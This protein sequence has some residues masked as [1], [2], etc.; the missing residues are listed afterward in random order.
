MHNIADA[1][2]ALWLGPIIWN[3]GGSLG[4]LI[5]Y[6]GD[7]ENKKKKMVIDAVILG[8]LEGPVDGLA[9][10]QFI[11]TAI[12]NTKPAMLLNNSDIMTCSIT[13]AI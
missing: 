9:G 7:D 11:N 5:P 13:T 8:L 12:A 3:L 4:Y 1:I 10:G 2:V 6:L